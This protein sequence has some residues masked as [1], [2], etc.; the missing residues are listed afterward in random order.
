MCPNDFKPWEKLHV[1]ESALERMLLDGCSM[2]RPGW[3]LSSRVFLN[4]HS[5]VSWWALCF[6]MSA[7]SL[8]RRDVAAATTRSSVQ[9]PHSRQTC[10]FW[11]PSILLCTSA[12][13]LELQV[14]PAN[15]GVPWNHMQKDRLADPNPQSTRRW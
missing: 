12:L 15:N 8:G 14:E 5:S 1:F 9:D 7:P 3:T 13:S 4:V 10:S 6:K 2:L 11:S